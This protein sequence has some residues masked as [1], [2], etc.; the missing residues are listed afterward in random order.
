[1][2]SITFRIDDALKKRFQKVC[3]NNGLNMSHFIRQA[4]MG[5]LNELEKQYPAIKGK[6]R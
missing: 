2:I 4:I 6:H 3:K 1:M 5:K